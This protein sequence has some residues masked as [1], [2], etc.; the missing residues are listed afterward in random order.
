[1]NGA[2]L[3][4][5][6]GS[7]GDVILTSATILN[8]KLNFPNR[9]L[10]FV[11]KER[12]RSIVDL[13]DG[14]D[15]ILTIPDQASLSDLVVLRKRLRKFQFEIIVD[16]HGNYR[17]WLTRTFLP[18]SE[19]IVYPKRRL[20]RMRAV[21]SKKNVSDSPHTIDLYNQTVEQLGGQVYCRRPLVQL[22]SSPEF[23]N[24][25][26]IAGGRP[27]VIAPGAAH[28]NKQWPLERF[29]EVA[30]R[31][32]ATHGRTVIWAVTSGDAGNSGLESRLP[33]GMFREL[34]DSPLDQLARTLAA[35]DL[36]IANDSGVAHLAS[37]V[38]TPVLAIFG[39]THPLLGFSPRGRFDRVVQVDEECRP[40]S[41]H[42]KKKCYR[43]ERFCFTRITAE[44]VAN[45]AGE[46]LEAVAD[47]SPA[48][49]VDRDGT[50]IENKH[51]LSDPDQVEIIDGAAEALQ[52][53]ANSGYK[54]VIVSNQSGVARG[55][56]G[57]EQLR[58][59]NDR[60][61]SMLAGRGVSVAGIYCCPH[62]EHQ[63]KVPEFSMA[64]D[65]RK[66]RGGLAEKAALE[67]GLD[68]R[69]SV[70]VGDSLS[71]IYLGRVIGC[72][73]LLVRT[74][75]GAEVEQKLANEGNSAAFGVYDDLAMAVEQGL[76]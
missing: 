50:I 74:G 4:I 9:R 13:F 2:I 25:T 6:F 58:A 20:E 66:P 69:A 55:Y 7:L 48:L 63:G 23:A 47:L 17:S 31:L 46:R 62:H 41:R 51:Y 59:V 56:F 10:I 18:A 43:E 70:V 33:E 37:A 21:R 53:A 12:F 60:L 22:D 68:L 3:V 38:D 39:P 71:D 11:T 26:G 32:H 42:G 75:Y 49:F 16:L 14:V 27:I 30:V 76:E 1:M 19:R 52:K 61:L 45:L 36:V 67:L 34:V 72:R 24:K 73:S 5:R 29:A 57:M 54:I 44:Q 8:L 65:C 35:A 15:E 64:C 28:A 40:C